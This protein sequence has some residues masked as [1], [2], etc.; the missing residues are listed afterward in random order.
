MKAKKI[1]SFDTATKIAAAKEKKYGVVFLAV[2]IDTGGYVVVKSR[3][4]VAP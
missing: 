1:W 3:Y 2:P 4:Q